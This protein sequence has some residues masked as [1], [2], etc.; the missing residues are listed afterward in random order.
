[1]FVFTALTVSFAVMALPGGEEAPIVASQNGAAQGPAAPAL[2]SDAGAASRLEGDADGIPVMFLWGGAIVSAS[3]VTVSFLVFRG[4]VSKEKA[5]I[6]ARKNRAEYYKD[7]RKY[8]AQLKGP[9]RD[10]T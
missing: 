2:G 8:N 4:E 3:G 7:L 6:K 5:A 1:M 9:P 10:N